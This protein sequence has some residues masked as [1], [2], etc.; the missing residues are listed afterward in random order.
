M[1]WDKM[2]PTAVWGE[3]TVHLYIYVKEL[4]HIII[5]AVI[6]GSS[7]TGGRVLMLNM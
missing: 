5:A 1:V 2:V 3:E 7:W 4:I 6:W